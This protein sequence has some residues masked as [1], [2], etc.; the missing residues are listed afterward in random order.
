MKKIYI[1]AIAAAMLLASCGSQPAEQELGTTD[2]ATPHIYTN[3]TGDEFPILAWFSLLGD[4]VTKERYEEMAEAGFNISFSHFGSAEQVEQAL[5]ASNG[6]GVKILVT[7]AEMYDDTENAV[8]RF[9]HHPQTVGYF[10]RDEP[11]GAD[12]P[13]LAELADNIRKADDTKLLYLNLFPNYVSPEHLGAESY[14]DHVAQFIRE[15][16]LGMVSFD[17]YPVVFDGVRRDYFY[18]NLED[19]ASEAKKAGVPFWAFSLSTAHDPYPVA[20]RAAMRLQIFTNLA[21]GAQGIQYFTY[22]TPG[23]ETWNFHNAPIDENS[24]RTEVWDRVAE[25]NHEVKA[26]TKVFL[27]AEMLKVRHTG[28]SIPAGTVALAEGDLPK[29]ITKV[30]AEKEGVTVSQLKNGTK[31]YLMIVNHDIYVPQRVTV[32]CAAEVMRY[33]PN[34]KVVPASTYSP[35]LYVEPGDM[36]LFGW[37]EKF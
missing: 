10:L 32:E 37:R 8:K 3:P 16:K 4:Q 35:S 14:A 33:L 31:R 28:E 24:Q 19:V 25:I 18:A 36:L 27:G 5:E 15:V 30:E 1:L 20:D 29:Q 23:T 9:R 21:Y 34:G 13:K 17:H 7:C 12:F 11:T 2:L 6:T 26:L 22:T